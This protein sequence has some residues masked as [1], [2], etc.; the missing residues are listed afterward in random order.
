MINQFTSSIL[1]SIFIYFPL[2]LLLFIGGIALFILSVVHIFKMYR[3]TKVKSFLPLILCVT[4][5]FLLIDRPLSPLFQKIEFSFKLDKREDVARQIIN[6]KIK[7]S[8]DRGDLFL[9]PKKYNKFFLSDGNEVMKIDDK[10]FFFTVRGILDNFAGYVFS[11]SGVEPTNE[12]VQATIIK[13][14]K[15]NNNWYYISC[16]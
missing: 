5:I 6:D 9:V 4:L 12:D 1:L 16:T 11:P 7:P 15:M 3:K 14:Q 8:N 10:L 2:T 13:I